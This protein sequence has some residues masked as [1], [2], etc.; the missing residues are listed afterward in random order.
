MLGVGLIV[1]LQVGAASIKSSTEASLHH[2]FPVDVIVRSQ[3]GAL[4]NSVPREVRELPGIRAAI[5]VPSA[6]VR[7]WGATRPSVTR[8]LW[9][10]VFR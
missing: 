2:E 8:S 10:R 5:T 6:L 7:P 1:T 3:S 4:P 9:A